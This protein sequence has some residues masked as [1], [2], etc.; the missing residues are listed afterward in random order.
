MTKITQL[1][2]GAIMGMALLTSC[3]SKSYR[4]EGSGEALK[5][6]DTLFLTT[7]LTELTPSDTIVVKDGKFAITGETDSTY[8]CL[9]YSA[10]NN[11]I[12][13]PFFVEPGTVRM[14]FPEKMENARVAGTPCNDEWQTVSDSTAAM[15]QKMSQL[16]M[17]MYSGQ[18][19]MESQAKIQTEIEQM[20]NR[21]RQFIFDKGK[22]NISNEFG[23]FIVTFYSG[24]LLTADQSKEL[25]QLMPDNLRQR[26]PIRQMEESLRMVQSTSEGSQINDFQMTDMD[27]KPTSILNEVKQHKITVLD[28]WAS[29][30]GPCRQAMP[31]VIGIYQQYHN[32]GLGIIGISLDEQKEAW[33]A[34]IKELGMT[35][36]QVSDLKGWDNAAA[37]AFGVRAIPHMIVLDQQGRIIKNGIRPSELEGICADKCK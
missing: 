29:W 31:Q 23:Y 25:I 24:G 22:K 21:F 13:M 34:A 16:A 20:N 19:S 4:L 36:M 14:T 1:I 9:L 3:Q 27:G 5:D 15:S 10:K 6:G 8:F 37:Q 32:K 26:Q 11:T 12:A 30:C 18:S 33:T 17:Q 7:D 28:F 2:A 35:W